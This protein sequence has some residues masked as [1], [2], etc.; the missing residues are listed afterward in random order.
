M[1]SQVSLSRIFYKFINIA[2]IGNVKHARRA[3]HNIHSLSTSKRIM[4]SVN[5]RR[6]TTGRKMQIISR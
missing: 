4:I 2:F 6:F 5:T 3:P 1:T